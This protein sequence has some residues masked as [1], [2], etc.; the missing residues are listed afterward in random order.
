LNTLIDNIVPGAADELY[1]ILGRPRYYDKTWRANN[2]IRLTPNV[3]T[4]KFEDSWT[5]DNN[6]NL[7]NMRN[8]T[9]I[10]VKNITTHP[11]VG[12]KGWIQC[13]IEGFI[14]GSVDL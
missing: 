14:S 13:K 4:R 2:T 8:D 10:F 11:I 9:L 5:G 7:I 3:Y 12:S 6:S 1:N